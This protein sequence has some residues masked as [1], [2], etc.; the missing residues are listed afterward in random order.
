[1]QPARGQNGRVAGG[2]PSWS[3][4]SVHDA[5]LLRRMGQ[6]A[7][8]AEADLRPSTVHDGSIVRLSERRK[9]MQATLRDEGLFDDARALLPLM[10]HGLQDI[11]H[12]LPT[13]ADYIVSGAGDRFDAHRDF[14][15]V[16]GEGLLALAF[17]VCLEAPEEGG[18]ILLAPWTE[19]SATIAYEAGLLIL[20][21]CRM[22]HAALPVR[23]GQ[24]RILKFDVL[25]QE[26]LQW[27]ELP[28]TGLASGRT[29]TAVAPSLLR[30]LDVFPALLSFEGAACGETLRTDL[31]EPCEL[32]AVAQFFEG[33]QQV[34]GRLQYL[35]ELLDRL[36]CPE[37]RLGLGDL[38]CL[39]Q[40]YCVVL[41]P[42]MPASTFLGR[43]V[44]RLVFA[45][46]AHRVT[47]AGREQLRS[48]ALTDMTGEAVFARTT[49][50]TGA[51]RWALKPGLDMQEVYQAVLDD[52]VLFRAGEGAEFCSETSQG[53]RA[54]G[55]GNL[56]AASP[57][58]CE[59]AGEAEELPR[60]RLPRL[61]LAALVDPC[62]GALLA[63]Q[64]QDRFVS[65]IRETEEC[66][67][68]DTYT[69]M[70]YETTVIRRGFL[71]CPRG[72]CLPLVS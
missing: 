59:G 23:L 34:E 69:T 33:R 36:C 9:S 6:V 63:T 56:H 7:E 3:V 41:D 35:P 4:A 72:R 13:H 51:A 14:E 44:P 39:S 64:P 43:S 50:D 29:R 2:A 46:C 25:A 70:S 22:E 31:L 24:K 57:S 55:A 5:A 19:Q 8:R 11:L 12:L 10:G 1:M 54:E 53:E 48:L 61:D 26:G 58:A 47:W 52:V 40:G 62:V 15:L 37:G 18:E 20:F 27:L 30:A 71:L 68:G 60:S 38:D 28:A 32:S 66:N 65:R 45:A 21:P 49:G 17:I 67:D 16:A 42:T